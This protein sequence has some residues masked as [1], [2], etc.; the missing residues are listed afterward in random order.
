MACAPLVAT[1][2]GSLPEVVGDAA[3]QVPP[4]NPTALT[5]AIGRVRNSPAL[6]TQLG[7]ATRRLAC[8]EFSWQSV[9]QCTVAWYRTQL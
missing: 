9:A 1:T 8:E 2:A 7:E 5:A 6:A 4:G 3:V